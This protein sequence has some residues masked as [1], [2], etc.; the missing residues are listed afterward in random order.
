MVAGPIHISEFLEGAIAVL[1]RTNTD[2]L[3]G[4]RDSA[5]QVVWGEFF[6][7]YQP[8]LVAFARKLG[9]REHD[10]EDAAQETLIKFAQAYRE[11]RYERDRGRLRTWLLSIAA[12]TVRDL[13]RRRRDVGAG[14]P[15]DRTGLLEQVP[16]D[17]SM[18]EVW[19]AEWKRAI[20]RQCLAQVSQRVSPTT[21][22]AFELLTLEGWSGEQVA[23]HLNISR[24]AVYLAKIHVLSHMRELQQKME[25]AW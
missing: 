23:A 16:D 18:S 17:A 9:L 7:R 2:L 10:A 12:N 24:N 8:I 1:T 21:L 25:E 13:Q 20:V 6:S 14:A 4:L 5:D 15:A 3:M 19:E 22:R 11:G